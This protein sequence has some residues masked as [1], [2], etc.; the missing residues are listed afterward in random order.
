MMFYEWD[1]L[2]SIIIDDKSPFNDLFSDNLMNNAIFQ[3][4]YV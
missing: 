2:S 1:V 3:E 4:G